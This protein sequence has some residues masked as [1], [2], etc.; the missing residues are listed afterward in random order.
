MTTAPGWEGLL[1]PGEKIL[2]QGHPDTALVILPSHWV[3]GIFGFFF[4]G[5]ALFWMLVAAAA[6]GWTWTFGLIH[7]TVGLGVMVGGPLLSQIIRRGSTYTL[8]D[9]RAFI[10]T[11]LPFVGRKLQSWPITADTP[12]EIAETPPFATLTFAT[13]TVRGRRGPSQRPVGFERITD[14]RNVLSLMR[15]IQTAAPQDNTP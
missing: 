8:T 12:L 10:A 13:R 3:T 5:F 11:D 2:W 9:R 15:G 4:A 1:D 6:G 7:F 14:G